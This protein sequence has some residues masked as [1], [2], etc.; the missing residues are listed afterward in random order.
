MNAK[1]YRHVYNKQLGCVVVAPEIARSGAHGGT[2]NTTARSK[3]PALCPLGMALVMLLGGALHAQSLPTGGS[4]VGGQGHIGAAGTTMTV[5]QN[6]SRLAINWASFNIGTGNTVVFNQPSSQAVALNTVLG[7]N[8]SQIYGNLQANGQ[9]FLIN[10]NG[11]L[12]GKSAQVSVGG[13][14]AS[15][16]PIDTSAFMQG[17]N[18]YTFSRNASSGAGQVINQGHLKAV[19]GGFVVLAGD[20]VINTGTIDATTGTVALASGDSVTLNLDN[21]GQLKV[22]VNAATLGALIKSQGLIEADGGQV[23]L[24]ARGLDQLQTNVMNLSG[25]IDARS[26]GAKNGRIVI[27]GGDASQ[28]DSGTVALLDATVDASGANA[29]EQGGTVTITGPHVNLQGSAINV[30]GYAGG[31][32]ALVGGDAHGQGSLTHALTTSMD[33]HS[34]IDASATG[35]GNGGTVVLWSDEETEFDG[36]IL[37]RGGMLGGNG[38]HVETSSENS[39]LFDPAQAV[40]TRA[41]HGTLGTLLLDPLNIFVVNGTGGSNS[42]TIDGLPATVNGTITDGELRS[43]LATSNVVLTASSNISDTATV[44]VTGPGSLTMSAANISL[45]GSYNVTGGMAL[46]VTGTGSL[47]GNIS[48]TGSL[49]ATGGSWSITEPNLRGALTVTNATVSLGNNNNVSSAALINSTWNMGAGG[50]YTFGSQLTLNN[51]T[52]SLN[53]TS[54]GDSYTQV[55]S[56]VMMVGNNSVTMYGTQYQQGLTFIAGFTGSG[57][58]SLYTG[59]GYRSL[60][61]VYGNMATYSGNVTAGAANAQPYWVQFNSNNGWGTG[62]LTVTGGNVS[63]NYEYNT[64]FRIGYYGCSSA[65]NQPTAKL[66]IAGGTFTTGA[67]MTIGALTGNAGGTLNLLSDTATNVTFTTGLLNDASDLFAG[68]ITGPGNLTKVGTGTQILTGANNN[69]GPTLV[70]AGTL[71]VGNNGTTG[72]LGTGK[73]TDNANLVFDFSNTQSLSAISSNTSGITGTGNFTAEMGGGLTVDRIVNLSGVQSSITLEAGDATPAGTATGGDVTFNNPVN[74]T[75]GGTVTIFQ[76]NPNTATLNTSINGAT[77]TTEYKTYDASTGMV[78]GAVA[79]TRNFY[80][81]AQPLLT[82]A[83]LTAAKVYDGTNSALG[84]VNGSNATVSGQIEGDQL[85]LANLSLTSAT[86]NTSHAGAGLTLN[87]GYTANTATYNSGGTTWVVSGYGV[88]AY[89]NTAAANVITPAPVTVTASTQTKTYDGTTTSTTPVTNITGLVAGD[90]LTGLNQFYNSSQVLGVNG[91]SLIVNSGGVGVAGNHSSLLSDYAITYVNNTGTITPAPVT[92]TASTQTKV[93]DGTT[94]SNLS[95][96]N[97]TGLLA[98]DNLTGLLQA[99]NSSHALGTNGSL[100]I[101]DNSNVGVTG[102]HSSSLSD[103]AVSYVSTPGTITPA[104]VTV[105]AST[106]TKVYDGT[107]AS[108]APVT[109]ITGLVAGDSLTG[110]NQYYNSSQVLGTNGSTLIVNS[111]GVGIIGNHSSLLSDYAIA[112]ADNTGTITPAPVTVTAAADTKVFDATTISTQNVTNITGLVPGDSLTGLFQAYNNSQ[113]LGPNDSLLVVNSSGV[114]IVG[115]NSSVLNDYAI[116]YVNTPGT[117]TPASVVVTATSDTKVYDGTTVSNQGVTNITGLVGGDALTGLFQAYNSSHALGV[118]DSSLVVNN[119]DVGVNSGNGDTLSDYAISYV[120]TPG[121]ITPASV[122]VAASADTKV[123][124]STTASNATVTNVTGLL[125]GD[126]LTGLSQYYNS[127]QVLGANGSTLIVNSSDVGVTGNHASALTDYAIDYVNASGTVAQRN[128]TIELNN[129]T[130]VYDGTT[131]AYAKGGVALPATASSGLIAGDKIV[132]IAGAGA[133]NSPHVL[134]AQSANFSL[135]NLT[136][137]LSGNDLANYHITLIQPT[138]AT[139]TPVPV[140]VTA[141]PQTKAYDSTTASADAVTNISGLLPGDSLTGLTQAY[142]DPNAQGTNGSTL[143]VNSS[144]VGMSSNRGSSLSDY[145]ISYVA[146]VGTITPPPAAVSNVAST[147]NSAPGVSHAVP[148]EVPPARPVSIPPSPS[149]DVAK[150][151]GALHSTQ[152]MATA[153]PPPWLTVTQ[154][155]QSPQMLQVADTGQPPTTGPVNS[156]AAGSSA[157]GLYCVQGVMRVPDGVN[158]MPVENCARSR[159]SGGI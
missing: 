61:D 148:T 50:S 145:A 133:Y 86:F 91:S 58:V 55:N 34:S 90:S 153:F 12:F 13:L 116:S 6:S 41:P 77:G 115:N 79:G 85:G 136:I 109:N 57:N 19:N 143:V 44:N 111:S 112:Y 36:A 11:V 94:A 97:I 126:T 71:Q 62:T 144:D 48:G 15:T 108:A 47:G 28:G 16:L 138:S 140:S 35:N 120:N 24:T 84:H 113:V 137:D 100:L 155:P 52:V 14:F 60:L 131:V 87:A 125:P 118:G 157:S 78:S 154:S 3:L 92:V 159:R 33:A 29:G 114:S 9:V 31:G 82:V 25:V 59:S 5:Q 26:I 17:G 7:N 123:Y 146:S 129:V 73:V 101:V 96:T 152:S 127:S 105:T 45:V 21:F 150:W 121:T 76:G 67:N 147:G 65:V 10:P 46:T 22:S 51:T 53:C 107:T 99:Y 72:T 80:Y 119:S 95:V 27:D 75:A 4:I 39:L 139:I 38:G 18:G 151:Q 70:S 63:V 156:D 66:V 132:S 8:P 54:C 43:E 110:L 93:Y 117:I 122:I 141:T 81:R 23:L 74:V 158:A 106:D 37:G 56:P 104:A 30:S 142:T 32:T 135:A 69:S 83:N 128:L 2:T 130:K 124:D 42:S 88:N 89:S 1:L 103:Y 102:N 40:D 98:G 68:V 149:I 134:G 20:Q 49:T 64:D